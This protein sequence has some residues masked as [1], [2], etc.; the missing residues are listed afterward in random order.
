MKKFLKSII[1]LALLVFVVFGLSACKTPLSSTTV[2]ISKTIVN[3]K[4]SNGGTAVVYGDYLYY[5]NGTQKNDGTNGRGVT[6][7]AI[8]KIKYDKTTGEIEKDAEAEVVVS[9]LVGYEDGSIHIF[10]DFLYYTTP[11][12]EVNYQGT[13]LYSKTDFKRYD[14]VNGG[15]HG[16]YTTYQNNSSETVEYAYYIVADDLYLLV[17]ENVSKTLIS[18]KIG[19]SCQTAYKI[20]NVESCMLSSNY[21]LRVDE[22]VVDANNFVFYTKAPSIEVDGYDEGSKVYKTAPNKDNSVWMGNSSTDDVWNHNIV[23]L[24]AIKDGKL[25]YSDESVLSKGET[26]IYAQSIGENSK[27]EFKATDVI[28][29]NPYNGEDDMIMFSDNGGDVS[30]IAYSSTSYQIVYIQKESGVNIPHRLI[31]FDAKTTVDFVSLEKIKESKTDDSG[32]VIGE[33]EVEYLIYT[34]T[35]DSKVSLYKLEVKRNGVVTTSPKLEKIVDSSVMLATNG[36][37]MP[38]TIGNNI[39]VVASDSDKKAYLYMLDISK[40]VDDDNKLVKVGNK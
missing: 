4:S 34:V 17:Y 35:A 30:I 7:G 15:T 27:L 8:C 24:L 23:K 22:N 11:N 38:K 18:I 21:G 16:I 5:I 29:S 19:D 40:E 25:I 26:L 1:S 6:Q 2:D 12:N 37:I 31:G 36:L 3:G 13:T 20:S 28:S 10:G 14:L 39:F 32:A 9:D 33:D